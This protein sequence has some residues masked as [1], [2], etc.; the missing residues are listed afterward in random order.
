MNLSGRVRWIFATRHSAERS[1]EGS[2]QVTLWGRCLY[3]QS[4]GNST[5]VN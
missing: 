4:H 1:R 2:H 5:S 3:Q